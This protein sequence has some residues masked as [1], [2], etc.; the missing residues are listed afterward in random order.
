MATRI[1]YIGKRDTYRDGIFETGI[2]F[3]KNKIYVI[4]DDAKARKMLRHVDQYAL[5]DA[6]LADEKS[7]D[8]VQDH[9]VLD[10]EVVTVAAK[11]DEAVKCD[12]KKE[13]EENAAQDLRDSVATMT[14]Q[15]LTDF[16][17]THFSVSLDGRKNVGDLRAQVVTLIDQY[18]LGE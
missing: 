13:Q 17:K 9:V 1:K 10:G 16:A 15:T 2:V 12:E 3:E 11:S 5:A 14:K 7:E 6:V 18:G 4:E 8:D